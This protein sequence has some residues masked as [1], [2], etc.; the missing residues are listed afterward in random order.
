MS[1]AP[2][3]VPLFL[4]VKRYIRQMIAD[5]K[6]LP[7]E[8]IPPQLE[9]SRKLGVSRVTVI[10]AI[11]ELEFEG[12]LTARRGAGTFVNEGKRPQYLAREES[13]YRTALAEETPI[14][15]RILDVV[16]VS[17]SEIPGGALFSAAEQ[18]TRIDRVRLIAD[19]PRAYNMAF[20]P[21]RLLPVHGSVKK[22]EETAFY[23]FLVDECGLVVT[24]VRL[25]IGAGNLSTTQAH[26]LA[27]PEGSP[28]LVF[29]RVIVGLRGEPLGLSLGVLPTSSYAYFLE[30]RDSLQSGEQLL[31]RVMSSQK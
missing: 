1:K 23:D 27:E 9:L 28:A 12:I 7:N 11:Q 8:R 22:L 17:G 14:R 13:L 5:K 19:K 31:S 21:S 26:H 29:K 10:R 20:V 6:W 18:L 24:S 25:F 16:Q 2:S 15:H 3:K 4:E 30:F